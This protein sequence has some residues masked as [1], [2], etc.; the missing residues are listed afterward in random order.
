[1]LDCKTN[2]ATLE[3]TRFV[4]PI[5]LSGKSFGIKLLSVYEFLKCELAC[6][7]L[8]DKLVAQGYEK[9]ICEEVCERA[10]IVSLC[11]YD[12]NNERVFNDG[13]SVLMRLTPEE[14]Q[15]IYIEYNKLTNKIIRFNKNSSKKIDYI[16]KNY[17]KNKLG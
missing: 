9:K 5:V 13:L 16:K 15:N 12:K 14:L 8:I 11:F 4:E 1:M 17:A 10:C 6:R 7:N 3:I 2:D